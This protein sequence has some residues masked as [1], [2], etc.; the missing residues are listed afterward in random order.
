MRGFFT[1]HQPVIVGV[2]VE[3]IG[4]GHDLFAIGDP[5][6]ICIGVVRIRTRR[7]L[8]GV[9]DA[10]AVEVHKDREDVLVQKSVRC[11]HQMVARGTKRNA[12]GVE[13]GEQQKVGCV[14]AI[15]TAC[16][17][18]ISRL[19]VLALDADRDVSRRP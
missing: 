4:T 5:V 14:D 11:G 13:A 7:Y 12:D 10:V 2:G 15:C 9:S 19:T 16:P 3:R 8:V 1:V 17:Q 6:V 18:G